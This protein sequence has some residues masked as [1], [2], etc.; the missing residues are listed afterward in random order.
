MSN[1]QRANTGFNSR[2]AVGD[3]KG[4]YPSSSVRRDFLAIPPELNGRISRHGYRGRIASRHLHEEVEM[5]LA[6]HGSA[7]YLVGKRRYRLAP[8]AMIWLFPGQDHILVDESPDFR[9]WVFVARPVVAR[10]LAKRGAEY[11]VLAED[12]PDGSFV[13]RVDDAELGRLLALCE[14]VEAQIDDPVS[15]NCAIEFAAAASWRAFLRAAATD[16]IGL[17]PAVECAVRLLH[18]EEDGATIERLAQETGLSASRL[19]RLFRAQVGV[20]IAAFRNA[21]R[22]ERFH[23]LRERA[24]YLNLAAAALEAGFGSYAQ[25]YRVY[26]AAHGRGPAGR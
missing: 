20:P 25:F 7:A 8:G 23:R 13:R 24:P 2:K 21:Q 4:E 1:H 3:T 12:D 11:A 9:M 19:S 22:L 17:H 6:F 18:G 26:V 16:S 10:T 14:V 15:Y 5:N